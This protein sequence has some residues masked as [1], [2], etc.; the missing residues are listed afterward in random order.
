VKYII[1]AFLSIVLFSRCTSSSAPSTK[2][3]T[4]VIP[5]LIPVQGIYKGDFDGNPIYI[6]INYAS[7]T[8]VAGYNTHKGLRRNLSGSIK[9]TTEGWELDLNEPGDH[10]F[11]GKFKLAFDTGFA[12]AKGQW[13]PLNTPSTLKE[14][15][16]TL[17]RTEINPN[18]DEAYFYPMDT[19]H[20]DIVFQ[21]DGNCI[22]NYYDKINDSTFAEQMN[23]VRGTWEKKDSLL[24]VTWHKTAQWNRDKSVFTITVDGKDNGGIATVTGEGYEFNTAF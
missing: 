5:Q 19:D 14:K 23:T 18:Q 7:G 20:A 2:D 8:H 4:A 22:F 3:T 16:F 12:S 17:T 10:P 21:Q 15:Q 11:D 9:P 6:I 1:G 13:N 24:L